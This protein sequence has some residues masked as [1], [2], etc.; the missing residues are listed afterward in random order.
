M[1][2]NKF[3]ARDKIFLVLYIAEADDKVCK[4]LMPM[5]IQK[6]IGKITYKNSIF[7]FVASKDKIKKFPRQFGERFEL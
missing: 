6:T 4:E 7:G 1:I 3:K 2:E 5:A